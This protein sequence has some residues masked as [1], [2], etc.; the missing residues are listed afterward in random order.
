ML[1][2]RE[3][4]WRETCSRHLAQAI[5]LCNDFLWAPFSP[6]CPPCRCSFTEAAA[7]FQSHATFFP[8]K[9]SAETDRYTRSWSTIL[10]FFPRHKLIIFRIIKR[11]ELLNNLPV[12]LSLPL[13]LFFVRW[14]ALLRVRLETV[15]SSTQSWSETK[16]P[17]LA[18]HDRHGKVLNPHQS[19]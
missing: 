17:R 14:R 3:K 4:V 18:S 6:D 11:K 10:L 12:R 1:K 2:K 19:I 16:V 5:P 8:L 15:S 13:P 7:M 9:H